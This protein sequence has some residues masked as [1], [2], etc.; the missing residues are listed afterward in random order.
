MGY[1][2]FDY[3]WNF[4]RVLLPLDLYSLWYD[5][6]FWI[7]IPIAAY[8]LLR[9]VFRNNL[10]SSVANGNNDGK[11]VV[12][13]V[14]SHWSFFGLSFIG[15]LIL[16]YL[17]CVLSMYYI[18]LDGQNYPLRYQ[19]RFEEKMQLKPK[20]QKEIKKKDAKAI[21]QEIVDRLCE[22]KSNENDKTKIKQSEKT[23]GYM[24]KTFVTFC[25]WMHNLSCFVIWLILSII[26]FF[27]DKNAPKDN[28]DDA[29]EAV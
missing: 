8:F 10:H 26:W 12:S 9:M 19:N 25:V 22:R 2:G 15:V 28:S 17:L 23:F 18:I 5:L 14:K 21:A 6:V 4:L 7:I 29:V 27:V 11:S 24:V 3:W 16:S 13:A 1:L 20:E